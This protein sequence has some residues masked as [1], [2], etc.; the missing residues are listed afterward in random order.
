M[1]VTVE[2]V[3]AKNTTQPTVAT[4]EREAYMRVKAKQ[5]IEKMSGKL[6]LGKAIRSIRLC[7]G[8]S[9]TA[10]AKRLKMSTQYLC[11]LEHNR[12]IVSPKKA[13]RIAEILGFSPEQFIALA[14]QDVL[15]RDGI[16][17]CVELKAA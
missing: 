14:I 6:T 10:F 2:F 16:R 5:H 7:E 3:G 15:N 11:D 1:K 17:L 12:K 9:Q 4:I 8:E 13:K